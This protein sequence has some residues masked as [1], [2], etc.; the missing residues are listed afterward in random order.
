MEEEWVEAWEED[1]DLVEVVLGEW[2]V[3]MEVA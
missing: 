1:L 3:V 2:E